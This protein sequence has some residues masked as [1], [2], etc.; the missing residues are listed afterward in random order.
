MDLTPYSLYHN[1]HKNVDKRSYTEQSCGNSRNLFLKE[2]TETKKP[3][4]Q[5][6]P[7]FNP[8]TYCMRVRY[9]VRIPA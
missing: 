3:L 2:I 4:E 8:G 9:T 5:V 1:F 7:G 6:T